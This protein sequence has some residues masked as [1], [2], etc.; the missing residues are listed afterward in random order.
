MQSKWKAIFDVIII[1]IIFY[2]CVTTVFIISFNYKQGPMMLL[3]D[4]I[5][6]ISFALDFFFNFFMEYQDKDTFE[7]VKNYKKIAKRYA[8]GWMVIDFISTFP[9]DY[10]WR[11]KGVFARLFRLGRLSKL[12]KVLDIGRFKR[13]VKAQFENSTRPDRIQ[14]QQTIMYMFKLFRMMISILILTYIMA[15]GWWAYVKYMYKDEH[16]IVS[17]TSFITYHLKKRFIEDNLN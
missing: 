11:G 9:F 1:I 16:G 4:N 7:Q 3:I 13:L 6:T 10:F 5:V 2:S 8:K 14:T 12:V 15:C 17:D